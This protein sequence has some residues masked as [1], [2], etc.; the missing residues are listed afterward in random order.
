MAQ[1]Y[2]G[3]EL[4]ALFQQ[5]E[6][7]RGT[8]ILDIKARCR[9]FIITACQQIRK[10]FDINNRLWKLA[11]Y[12]HPKKLMDHTVRS[13]MPSL[14]ELVKDVPRLYN[15]NI[16][17]LDDQWRDIVWQQFTDNVKKI[18]CKCSAILPIYL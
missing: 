17:I 11:S 15:Y 1:I 13:T 9:T 10:L 16:Q 7:Q 18:V 6:C 2:L 3:A 12:L 4:H 14:S 5:P 8:M